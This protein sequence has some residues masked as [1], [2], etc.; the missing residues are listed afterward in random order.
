MYRYIDIDIQTGLF[1]PIIDLL[2]DADRRQELRALHGSYSRRKVSVVL[3]GVY[4]CVCVLCVC[5]CVFV[6]CVYVYLYLYLYLYM[7]VCAYVYGCAWF[8]SKLYV[9]NEN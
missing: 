8:L 3:S 2:P 4:T 6:C 9:A 5:V 1:D 7:Y